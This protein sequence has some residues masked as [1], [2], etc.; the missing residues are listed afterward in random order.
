MVQLFLLPTGVTQAFNF[1]K[2]NIMH[3]VH[4]ASTGEPTAQAE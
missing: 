1:Q 2:Y 3:S 4:G